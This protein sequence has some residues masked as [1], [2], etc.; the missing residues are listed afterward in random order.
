MI[1][2]ATSVRRAA[3]RAVLALLATATLGGCAW[4]WG[5]ARPPYKSRPA[6]E[7]LS[8]PLVLGATVSAGYR[9]PNR[10]ADVIDATIYGRTSVTDLSHPGFPLDPAAAARSSIESAAPL[11]PSVVLAVDWVFWFVH[12]ASTP[13]ERAVALTEGLF[14]LET[15]RCPVFVG[16]LPSVSVPVPGP[17]PANRFRGLEAEERHALNRRIVDWAARKDRFFVLPV[18][19]WYEAFRFRGGILL[20]AG[21][22][23]F[24]PERWLQPDS[25]HPTADGALALAI[26]S[27]ES[28]C[29]VLPRLESND[30]LTDLAELREQLPR[31]VAD[32]EPQPDPARL[33]ERLREIETRMVR[34]PVQAFRMGSAEEPPVH[35]VVLAPFEIGAT[36]VT[37]AQW[38]AVMAGWTKPVALG[39]DPRSGRPVERRLTNPSANRGRPDLP[40]ENVSWNDCREFLRR[41]NRLAGLRGH[42]RFR[43]PTEAEWEYACRAGSDRRFCFGDDP[44][45]LGDHAWFAA[46]AVVPQPVGRLEANAWG[47]HDMHGN[48]AEW[49][50][51][52]FGPFP[53]RPL[54]DPLGPEGGEFRV[55]KGG[56]VQP[57]RP[58]DGVDHAWGCR[59]AVRIPLR[60]DAASGWVGFRLARSLR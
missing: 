54:I 34:L 60:P 58:L 1:T 38:Q 57:S 59:S 19:Q 29:G 32:P 11:S 41:L 12:R 17:G 26:L 53:D 13:G 24:A 6:P 21:E 50:A 40:V 46:N 56:S 28:A 23:E 42:R 39:P 22:H 20:G 33:G 37:Q 15:F 45:G 35:R 51:D 31:P 9:L 47:L 52:W 43:L 14:L 7:V 18:E 3:L 25:L 48:V 8:R 10:L 49:C 36:E 44:A 16:T 27:L 2:P 4:W 55:A 5:S 30:L